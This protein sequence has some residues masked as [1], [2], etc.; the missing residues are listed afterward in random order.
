MK[1]TVMGR[2]RRDVS[3]CA[4]RGSLA[5]DE[6]MTEEASWDPAGNRGVYEAV[7]KLQSQT[8]PVEKRVRF[9]IP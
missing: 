5:R 6:T 2:M 4:E 3:C 7:A 1:T 9:T 8:H